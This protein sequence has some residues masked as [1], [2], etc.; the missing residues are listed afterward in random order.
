MALKYIVDTHALLWFL[1]DN[2]KLGAAADSALRTSNSNLIIPSIA[3]AEAYWI[4]EKGRTP[5]SI[6][7]IMAAID[8]DPRIQVCP[9]TH[10][11][12]ERS[13]SLSAIAEMHDR[14]IVATALVLQDEGHNVS[15]ITKDK[16][17][18]ASSLVTTIW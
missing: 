18:S 10:T 17:I 1:G 16:N 7:A 12:V 8:N 6:T 9:L 14:Q 3:L 5:V 11:I 4:V 15:L 13:I 2:P